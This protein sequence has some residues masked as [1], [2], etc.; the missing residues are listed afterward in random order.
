MSIQF[1]QTLIKT[2]KP[3]KNIFLEFSVFLLMFV[4]VPF[5]FLFYV[6]Y[7]GLYL[8]FHLKIWFRVEE[9]PT[10]SLAQ[11]DRLAVHQPRR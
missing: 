9:A 1:I 3:L 10:G 2:S 11:P 8:C 5:H 4:W 7:E 6:L